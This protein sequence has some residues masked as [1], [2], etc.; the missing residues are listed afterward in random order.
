MRTTIFIFLVALLGFSPTCW[1][2]GKVTRPTQNKTTNVK[3]KKKASITSN[4]KSAT[5]DNKNKKSEAAGNDDK[6]TQ[7]INGYECVDLALPS[8]LKWGVTNLGAKNPEESGAYFAWGET[9]NKNEYSIE[10]SYTSGKTNNELKSEGITKDLQTLAPRQDAASFYRGDGWRIPTYHEFKE[11]MGQCD[12][13]WVESDSIAGYK[14]IGKNGNSI[15]LPAA[16]F[17]LDTE[18]VKEGG[19][20]HYWT[21]TAFNDM[22]N[23]YTFTFMNGSFNL[24]WNGRYFGR[25]IRPV[26]E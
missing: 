26:T 22:F 15:F 23:A 17:Y 1:G 14:I 3:K 2:Q 10:D 8:G 18:L 6:K 11:L 13:E 19:S 7:L 16:G 20:G 4:K 9:T 5:T 21:S 12:W 25:V 24:T